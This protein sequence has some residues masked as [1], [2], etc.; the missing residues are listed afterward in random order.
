[1]KKR[2]KKGFTII[3]VVLV[4]AIAGMIFLMVFI[5]LPQMRRNQRDAERKD[6]MMLFAE[7]LKKFQT[8]NRGALPTTPT[9]GGNIK[10]ESRPTDSERKDSSVVSSDTSW[11]AFYYDYLDPGF[12]DPEN[13]N[14]ALQ[15]DYCDAGGRGEACSEDNSKALDYTDY[16]IHVV[17]QATCTED[18]T[19]LSNNPRDFALLYRTENSGMYCYSAN[20]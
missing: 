11:A 15:I 9:G 13:D 4:L 16:T 17:L 5:A 2:E 3:E 7:A 10:V 6:D 1:M 12:A 14:Y 18:Y 19:V 8:N 20:S